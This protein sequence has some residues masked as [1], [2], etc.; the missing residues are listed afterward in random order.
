MV[1]LPVDMKDVM[2]YA[3]GEL[4]GHAHPLLTRRGIAYSMTSFMPIL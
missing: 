2:G 3:I 4:V 1:A